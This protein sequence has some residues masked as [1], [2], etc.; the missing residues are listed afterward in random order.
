MKMLDSSF[1]DD[2]SLDPIREKAESLMKDKQQR[3]R[4][5]DMF[6]EATKHR[7]VYTYKD[8]SYTIDNGCKVER[9]QTGQS[10]YT[11]L[12]RAVTFTSMSTHTTTAYL[13]NTDLI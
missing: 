9:T 5:N 3:L 13:R 8:T 1:I 10:R 7:P 6:D 12:E 2:P 4:L 11:T